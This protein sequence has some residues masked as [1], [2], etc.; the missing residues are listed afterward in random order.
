MQVWPLCQSGCADVANDLPL[1]DP[2]AL[3]DRSLGEMQVLGDYAVSVLDKHVVAVVFVVGRA[4]D[5]AITCCKYWGAPGRLVV[6]TVVG[7]DPL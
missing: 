3:F 4:D 6:D 5:L 1:L 2:L 7:F